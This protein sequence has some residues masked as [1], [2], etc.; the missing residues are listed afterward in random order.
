MKRKHSG[1][2]LLSL[3]LA[4][5]IALGT[6]GVPLLA[7]PSGEQVVKG[8]VQFERNGNETHIRASDGSII[9]YD[10][11]NIG[12]G[13]SVR[14][15]QPHE[16]ARV[17]NR[18]L[19]EGA[20]QID[21][22]LYANGQVY[23]VNPAGVFFGGSA[24][25]DVA[26]LV[27][28]A[29]NL[30]NADFLAGVD[31]FTH[32]Q[33]TV[34]NHGFIGAN[35]AALIGKHVAN[36]GHIYTE[37]GMAMLVAGEEVFL[38]S[39]DGRV[40]IHVEGAAQPAGEAR[41]GVEQRGVIDAGDGGVYLSAG[42]AY[43]LAVNHQGYTAGKE[44]VINSQSDGLVQV[45]GRLDASDRTKE[46]VGGK[47]DVL[48]EAIYLT[49]ATVDASGTKG[50]GKI[51]VGGD[52]HGE[53]DTPT[54]EIVVVDNTSSLR[55]DAIESGDGG[56]VVVWADGATA[57]GG[58]LSARGGARAGDGG[59]AEISGA[60]K[61]FYR[62]NSD[63]RAPQGQKGTLLL[64]PKTIT[65]YDGEESP[66]RQGPIDDL[67]RGKPIDN[68]LKIVSVGE[69]PDNATIAEKTLEAQ[70]KNA[71]ILLE[72][73]EKITIENLDD[74]EL[75]LDEGVSFVVNANDNGEFRME[76]TNDTIKTKGSFIGI[77]AKQITT[78][79]LNTS[80]ED[81]LESDGQNG[82]DI[83]LAAEN[84]T[85][86]TGS[87]TTNGGDGSENGG[88]AG[89][90]TLNQA[91][92]ADDSDDTVKLSTGMIK[93]NGGKGSL[94]GG[95]GGRVRLNSM[96]TNA[97]TL[98]TVMIDSIEAKGG[99]AGGEN[100]VN[101]NGEV[102]RIVGG[103]GGSAQINFNSSL[104]D[105][106]RNIK[107]GNIDVSGGKGTE[108][109]GAAGFIN[110]EA[111]GRVGSI[112][113][114]VDEN[115]DAT[116]EVQ[117]TISGSIVT[118]VLTAKGGE[119]TGDPSL[120]PP[121]D[122]KQ[123][124][125]GGV[126]GNVTLNVDLGTATLETTT[127]TSIDV[128]GGSGALEGGSAGQVN[129]NLTDDNLSLQAA[130]DAVGAHNESLAEGIKPISVLDAVPEMRSRVSGAINAKGGTVTPIDSEDTTSP[131]MAET[132]M[133]GAGGSLN[134]NQ[135]QGTI[136]LRNVDVSG[137]N[138]AAKG[139][140][141]GKI[142]IVTGKVV[143][144]SS[145]D[146]GLLAGALQS[147]GG[148]AS[149][150]DGTSG[151]NGLIQLETPD[152][153]LQINFLTD[154]SRNAISNAGITQLTAGQ[155]G[156]SGNSLHIDGKGATTS[157]VQMT[158]K[159]DIHANVTQLAKL[160]VTQQDASKATTID[161]DATTITVMGTAGKEGKLDN[162][163]MLDANAMAAISEVSKVDTTG[164]NMAFTYRL[165]DPGSTFTQVE[166]IDN[167]DGTTTEVESTFVIPAAELVINTGSVTSDTGE[168]GFENL[169][170]VVRGG[171]LGENENHIQ[172]MGNVSLR[173]TQIG[174]GDDFANSIKIG[175]RAT[176]GTN[177]LS[178]DATGQ[179]KVDVTGNTFGTVE[180]TQRDATVNTSSTSA[181]VTNND[182]TIALIGPNEQDP[183]NTLRV[184]GS[185]ESALNTSTSKTKVVLTAAAEN[186][187]LIISEGTTLGNS[188]AFQANG[189]VILENNAI[190]FSDDAAGSQL[191]LVADLDSN[192]QGKVGQ[193]SSDQVAIANQ[194][195]TPAELLLSAGSGIGDESQAL[196]TSGNIVIASDSDTGGIF[197][198]NQ[199][200]T[201][202]IG[203]VQFGTEADKTQHSRSGLTAATDQIQIKNEAGDITFKG[204]G[205]NLNLV[206]G[207]S[208]LY[209]VNAASKI[210][211]AAN[212]TIQSGSD[213]IFDAKIEGTTAPNDEG[214]EL[215]KDLVINSPGQ[216]RFNQDVNKIENL[217]TDAAGETVVATSIATRNNLSIH[218]RLEGAANSEVVGLNAGGK[219][220]L[221]GD[222][223]T[224][225][226]LRG[227]EVDAKENIEFTRTQ[228]IKIGDLGLGLNQE[229]RATTAETPSIFKRNGDLQIDSAGNVKIGPREKLAV[230][231]NLKVSGNEVRLVDTIAE[232]F[233]ASGERIILQAR[234]PSQAE[235]KDGSRLQDE[236]MRIVANQIR[237]NTQ[238][239]IENVDPEAPA[240][241]FATQ[242]GEVFVPD[243]LEP[244]KVRLLNPDGDALK[245][246]DIFSNE[247]AFDYVPT[248]PDAV[249]NPS[250]IIPT[251]LPNATR[252]GVVRPQGVNAQLAVADPNA[253][254]LLAYARCADL[255]ND[256]LAVS[257]ECLPQVAAGLPSETEEQVIEPLRRKDVSAN[258]RKLLANTT[259]REALNTALAQYQHE[260]GYSALN[261]D[262]FKRYLHSSSRNE[263]ATYLESVQQ[264][265]AHLTLLNITPEA[266]AL[267]KHRISR[268]LI[269]PWAEELLEDRVGT[270]RGA[271]DS[272]Y[273]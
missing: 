76:D 258:Y 208:Q 200:G 173:G 188:A 240:P 145:S 19:G 91:S 56:E 187:N 269:D 246:S 4:E 157:D 42:D 180:L 108:E 98:S 111:S 220:T 94:S 202:E 218:D 169:H 83:L 233:E 8:K 248:G 244:F 5:L 189:D 193:E 13:E 201:T 152:R 191:A 138:G 159:G 24:I 181:T 86:A 23:I 113:E 25:V 252:P 156:D 155:I 186:A 90:I 239:E 175:N 129:I 11:F 84:G 256:Q 251:P 226:N 2:K 241:T 167:G 263:A 1:I 50:G 72:A 17:L 235:Q 225:S 164:S 54:A 37:A 21:G 205:D 207:G 127:G 265:M 142:N 118:G 36:Y 87:L 163:S 18:V 224:N 254:A 103:D 105:G 104:S 74:N 52:F 7:A 55:A 222:I 112:V 217:T 270:L 102:V 99:A 115:G 27:A 172:S 141:A 216:T 147:A 34:E 135:V 250:E 78:G 81:S 85:L 57:F 41:W 204:D 60:E 68:K 137:G 219:V 146:I 230:G 22:G 32:L 245:S 70:A 35:Q 243:T 96:N 151:D 260:R 46:G 238:P 31:R 212:T 128:S 58:K 259:G 237:F 51:R 176:G 266:L 73:S 3:L 30:S 262:Q 214:M 247:A 124:L 192:L 53:G 77:L 121:K 110:M 185:G 197:V 126:G 242:N 272:R 198:T 26:N 131:Q 93:S 130:I 75:T 12:H 80:G 253:E 177:T 271:S 190:A 209:Q 211:V 255:G 179:A 14:F 39:N 210:D 6:P 33:G 273:H 67:L 140:N 264:L 106:N 100:A 43:S 162:D 196:L 66:E 125:I 228:K 44:I 133:G 160:S 119:A 150:E 29:G 183:A 268:E 89:S 15:I 38:A 65:I 148:I 184:R 123:L 257:D 9:E 61:L 236:G 199:T 122:A 134:I 232:T 10:K 120:E 47:V 101:N 71:R 223:G 132:S 16:S 231:G 63:L 20:S 59:F 40:V 229:G 158:A 195:A 45:S 203:Q 154:P 165:D 227:L 139:G 261:A 153:I 107:T 234:A 82:G 221:G 249:L 166:T 161:G 213:V 109:G 178:V 171:A 64:D 97:S 174:V 49:S 116:F 143:D 117:N 136:G 149:A 95:A 168:V 114:T 48:G 215:G 267:A 206:S 28:A 62:G 79:H 144:G 194:S 88:D 92:E 69:G 170:G 182:E